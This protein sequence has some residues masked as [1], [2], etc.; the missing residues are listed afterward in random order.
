MLDNIAR[1]TCMPDALAESIMVNAMYISYKFQRNNGMSAV[2]L[3]RLGFANA[4]AYEV[5]YLEERL[6]ATGGSDE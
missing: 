3:Q 5:S 1:V 6:E 4:L 2:E